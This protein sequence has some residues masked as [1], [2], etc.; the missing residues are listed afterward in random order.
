MDALPFDVTLD[1]FLVRAAL[2]GLGVALVAGP[3]GCVMVWRRM[4]FFGDALAHAGLLGVAIGLLV[5]G[6]AGGGVAA[7]AGTFAVAALAALALDALERR[8]G[9]TGDAA[10]GIVAHGA[11]A[12]ALTMVA[13]VPALRVDL[14]ALLLGDVL[15][16]GWGDVA[17]VWIGGAAV[18]AALLALWRPLVA[19]AASPDIAAAEGLRPERARRLFT[20]LVAAAVALAIKLVGALLVTALLIVPASAARRL[21]GAP[22]A[23]ALWAAGLAALATLAGLL[24]SLWLDAPPGP[25]VVL[26]AVALF[27]ATLV[28]R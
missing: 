21:A 18:L 22:E 14:E 16:V 1:G 11:L 27:G 5:S 7:A 24:A 17:L 12:L 2:A 19:L 25:A 28:R 6:G 10:L 26:A 8:G 15:T 9:V 4:A 20:L 13:L 23:M 3:L